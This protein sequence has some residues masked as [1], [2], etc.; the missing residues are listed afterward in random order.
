MAGQEDESV[1]EKQGKIEGEES[2][3][4][5]SVRGPMAGAQRARGRESRVVR[6]SFMDALLEI[7]GLVS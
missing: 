7:G 5:R 1:P 3:V 6:E 2:V 4:E